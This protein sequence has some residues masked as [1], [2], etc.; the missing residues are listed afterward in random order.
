MPISTIGSNSLNQTSDLTINGQTVG[1]GGGNVSTNT[2]HGVS[3][4]AANT[5][6][7]QNTAV[8]YQAG[9]SN[10]T[11]NYN[12]YVG[13]G[14][15]TS[16]TGAR[17]TFIGQ[18][19]GN[20]VTSGANNTIIGGYNG[21]NG[22]L[23]IRTASNYVVLADGNGNPRGWFDNNGTFILPK[24]AY[25]TATPPEI[26]IDS[27]AQLVTLT[28][29]SL[30]TF[31]AFSGMLIVTETIVT[32]ET[33]VLICGGGIVTIVSQT[34]GTYVTTNT[35]GKYRWFNNSGS[36]SLQNLTTGTCI[37]GICSLRSRSN[38]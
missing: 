28:A 14:A 30:V 25:F 11:A 10:T 33:A 22:G 31:S 15:G 27:A 6:G 19:A 7:I 34:A 1:K 16:T 21:N 8:G 9:Q 23:D 24:R 26:T 35:A 17:N 5:T 37:F 29:N 13:D 20:A 4:L 32:G 2:V 12:C 38:S 3:A 18:G 36:Y